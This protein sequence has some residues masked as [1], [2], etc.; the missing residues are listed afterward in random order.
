MPPTP[1]SPTIH[2]EDTAWDGY[3]AGA[4]IER[5]LNREG[6][7]NSSYSG[8]DSQKPAATTVQVALMWECFRDAYTEILRRF[9]KWWGTSEADVV[10]IASSGTY[11]SV[12][13][14]DDFGRLLKG[15]LTIAGV[16]LKIVS[17]EEYLRTVRPE[18]DGG[19]TTLTSVTGSALIARFATRE[20]TSDYPKRRLCVFIYPVQ[21]AA[22][23]AHFVY[24]ANAANLTSDTDR[25][26]LPVDAHGLLMDLMGVLWARRNNQTAAVGARAAQYEMAAAKLEGIPPADDEQPYFRQAYPLQ[27]DA[28]T[29]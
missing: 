9:E 13:T 25:I 27:D 1:V 20:P 17:T 22:F 15:G 11:P 8:T 3:L 14:P 19:G 12:D 23:T 5:A 18:T 4:L 28:I 10:A 21:T 7:T 29:L 24:R 2:G 16:P 26:R 6:M